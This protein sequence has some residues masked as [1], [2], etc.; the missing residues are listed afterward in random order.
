MWEDP[1]GE[2]NIHFVTSEHWNRIAA[3]SRRVIDGGG[4]DYTIRKFMI[5]TYYQIL[6]GSL[7]QAQTGCTGE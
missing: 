2:G 1:E 6:L 7:D 3:W 4:G 5:C